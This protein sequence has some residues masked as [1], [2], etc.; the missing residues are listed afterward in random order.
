M[1]RTEQAE[2]FIFRYMYRAA[3]RGGR[4]EQIAPGPQPKRPVIIVGVMWV[5]FQ[6]S[7]HI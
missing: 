4:G 2:Q 1:T 6:A 7:I 3:D 5:P